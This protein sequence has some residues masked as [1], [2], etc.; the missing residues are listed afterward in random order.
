MS[1]ELPDGTVSLQSVRAALKFQRRG[2]DTQKTRWWPGAVHEYWASLPSSFLSLVC[3][4]SNS[5]APTVRLPWRQG[6]TTRQTVLVLQ[7]HLTRRVPAER[8]P[9]SARQVRPSLRQRIWDRTAEENNPRSPTHRRSIMS[10]PCVAYLLGRV[11]HDCP[12]RDTGKGRRVGTR[13]RESER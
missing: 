10:F 1:A 9:R 4:P 11:R 7:G 5:P 3:A 12:R 13:H 2:V 6:M 8:V